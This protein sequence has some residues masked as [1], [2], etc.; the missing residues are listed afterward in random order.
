MLEVG[1]IF[2]ILQENPNTWLGYGKT[3]KHDKDFI[4]KLIKE[5]NEARRNKKFDM[6]DKIRNQL[7]DQGIEIEDTVQGTI[8]RSNIK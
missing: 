7:K 4:E 6:A 2:G 3:K 5:R 1:K 8:W